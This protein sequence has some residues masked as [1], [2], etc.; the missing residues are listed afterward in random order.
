M[1]T[2]EILELLK[3]NE[4][5]EMETQDHLLTIWFKK[6]FGNEREF[7]FQLNGKAV[8]GCKTEKTALKKIQSFLNEGFEII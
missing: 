4:S 8:S 3:E 1:K 5:I 7:L 6:F 2:T